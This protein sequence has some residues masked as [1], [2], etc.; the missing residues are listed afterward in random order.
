[1]PLIATRGAA[2]SRGFG[3]FGGGGFIYP[4]TS[5]TFTNGGVVGKTGPSLSTLQSVYSGTVWANNTALFNMTTQG[6]QTWTVPGSA[7]YRI[8]MA[9]A[10]GNYDS[11][12]YPASSQDW[13]YGATIQ[14]DITLIA[15]T[16]LNIVVGQMGQIS[17]GSSYGAGAGGG[18]SFVYTGSIGGSGL[19]GAAGGGGGA[20]AKLS[21][22][23]PSY[24]G[25]ATYAGRH[26]QITTSGSAGLCD[27]SYDGN[28]GEGGTN[29]SGGQSGGSGWATTENTGGGAGWASNG[30]ANPQ[31]SSANP[32]VRG[33]TFVGG[34][35]I[36][37]SLG[38]DGGFGGGGATGYSG[39]V[40]GGG[41]GGG[42][43][44]G[45]GGGWGASSGSAIGNG[46]APGGGGGSY[47]VSGANI[48][49]TVSGNNNSNG[50]V[51]IQLI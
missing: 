26:G 38:A 46:S 19:I 15:E 22:Y 11:P 43:S 41:G 5:H 12:S 32:E 7:V 31:I 37:S 35:R 39:G 16:Q 34:S 23:S 44:G 21:S 50:Y 14:F 51:T 8:T 25:A 9:G 2:S 29:G 4:F 28:P 36:S 13:G 27:G 33:T 3:R 17:T 30:Q 42:Y 45:G 48:V 18:G 47:I 40:A 1:M 6:I 24:G 49:S 10:S 20:G